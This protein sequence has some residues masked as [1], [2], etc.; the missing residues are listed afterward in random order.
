[1]TLELWKIDDSKPAVRFIVVSNP[2]EF[3]R[4]TAVSQSSIEMTDARKLQL[5]FWPRFR[6]ALRQTGKMLSLR[7]PRPRYR[8][9]MPLGRTNTHLSATANTYDNRIAVRVYL[10]GA[11]ADSMLAQLEPQKAEIEK[12]IGSPLEW[13]PHPKKQDKIIILRS[14]ADLQDRT[15]WDQ[16]IAWL[17]GI[18]LKFRKVFGER[19]RKLN[20]AKDV[21]QE[22][23]GGSE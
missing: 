12:E 4:Q 13:N 11:V 7:S 20:L 15:K 22:D 1:V 5:E 14:P 3:V 10:R 2:S 9:D 17:V 8:Y 6:D 18:S 23:E 16:Y 21:S 19:V